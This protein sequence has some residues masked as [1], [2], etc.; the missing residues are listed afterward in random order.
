MF[1][2]YFWGLE[3]GETDLSKWAVPIPGGFHTKKVG[4]YSTVKCG[5]QGTG[6]VHFLEDAVLSESQ[7]AKIKIYGS[8]RRNRPFLSPFGVAETIKVCDKAMF[9]DPSISTQLEKINERSH[10]QFPAT[11][12]QDCSVNISL[13]GT[14]T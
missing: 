2:E 14:A 6:E 7:P 13:D 11:V 5:L 1:W 4:I 3:G 9:H 8:T 10:S 12:T